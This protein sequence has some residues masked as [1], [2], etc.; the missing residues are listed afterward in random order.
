MVATHLGKTQVSS[1]RRGKVFPPQ[2]KIFNQLL[3]FPWN[4]N[5]PP[6]KGSSPRWFCTSI[7]KLSKLFLMSVGSTHSK[8]FE[9]GRFSMVSLFP[10]MQKMLI[11]FGCQRLRWIPDGPMGNATWCG[12]LLDSA[13]SLAQRLAQWTGLVLILINGILFCASNE[14]LLLRCHALGNKTEWIG[15]PWQSLMISCQR[16]FVLGF[17]SIQMTC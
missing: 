15:C 10:E 12:N 13:S 6:G 14:M 2:Y 5:Q 4:T 7:A 16:Y 11:K 1:C 3:F 8:I 9:L 17:R